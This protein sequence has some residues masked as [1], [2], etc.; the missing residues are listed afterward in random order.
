M[1]NACAPLAV[2]W[3]GRNFERP[4]LDLAQAPEDRRLL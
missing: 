1:V 4:A 3:S 2:D